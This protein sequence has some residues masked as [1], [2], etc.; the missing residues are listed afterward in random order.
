M[1]RKLKYFGHIKRNECL[2]RYIYEGIVEA[3]RVERQT[4][5][6]VEPGH[7]GQTEHNRHQGRTPRAR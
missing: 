4:T 1:R 6:E 7:I 2:E 5:E 3:R